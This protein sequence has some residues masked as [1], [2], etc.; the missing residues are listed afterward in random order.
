MATSS[1]KKRDEEGR[2]DLVPK[3][4]HENKTKGVESKADDTLKRVFRMC[5]KL[6]KIS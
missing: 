5:T 2:C 4:V 6:G 1:K 3:G